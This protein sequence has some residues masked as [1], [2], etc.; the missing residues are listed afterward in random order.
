MSQPAG[1]RLL[2]IASN[3]TVPEIAI[4]SDL[5]PIIEATKTLY[6]EI[7]HDPPWISYIGTQANLSPGKPARFSI[8]QPKT[9]GMWLKG[10]LQPSAPDA[11]RRLA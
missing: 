6:M 8:P 3:G 7:G 1:F 5:A 10:P 9:L 2:A 4:P 11:Q